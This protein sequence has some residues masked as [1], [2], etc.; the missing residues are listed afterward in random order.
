MTALFRRVVNVAVAP[1]GSGGALGKIESGLGFDLSNLDCV[2]RAKKNLKAEPNTCKVKLYG[3]AR[4]TRRVLES[5]KKLVL[6]LE[7]GYPDSVG[8]IYLGEIRTAHTTREGPDI[9]TEIDTGDSEQA[10]QG[11]RINL[12]VGP[13]VPTS[14]AVKAIVE[15]LGVGPGNAAQFYAKLAA[16]GS[17]I[18]GQGSNVWG[19][20]AQRLTDICRSAD[21]EWSIQDGVLQFLDRGK[22]LN[23]KAVLL[24]SETGLVGSPSVD[25]KGIVTAQALI[26]PDLRPG[27]KVQFDSLDFKG[28]YR[29]EECEYSGDTA[30][31]E[32]Y[33]KMA[34]KKY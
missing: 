31:L 24:S 30:S 4:E 19:K 17:A 16:G 12:S 8:Q 28:G 1:A 10:I 22:A 29:I 9:V 6:R 26:Q 15:S 20:S 3:L 21:L 2:F 32:W 23:D 14:V 34:C 5:P 13:K 25:Q 18:F 11:S 7:A 27:R 33:V